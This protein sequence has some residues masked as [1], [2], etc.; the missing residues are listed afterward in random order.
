MAQER[1]KPP[2]PPRKKRVKVKAPARGDKIAR[3]RARGQRGVM[4]QVDK[5]IG[6]AEGYKPGFADG[7]FRCLSDMTSDV[8]VQR[9]A[10]Q[11]VAQFADRKE[12]V[13]YILRLASNALRPAD[14]EQ[15][16][17]GL[18]KALEEHLEKAQLAMAQG[19][20]EMPVGDDDRPDAG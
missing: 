19:R 10:A 2:G 6:Y 15:F 18:N 4:D 9:T 12:Q 20:T 17:A 5:V 16:Q 13:A 3:Q 14:P 7:Y 1:H 8:A 11:V